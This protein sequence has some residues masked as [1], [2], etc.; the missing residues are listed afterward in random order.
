MKPAE[1]QH[2]IPTIPRQPLS[3]RTV[4]VTRPVEQSDDFSRSLIAQG[5]TVV[6]FPTIAIAS[7]QSWDE[8]DNAVGKLAEYDGLV[9]TSSNAVRAF[10]RRLEHYRSDALLNHIKKMVIYVIG[11]QTGDTV[12]REGATPTQLPD[13]ADS[14]EF[15][16]ALVALPLEG[17]H[18]LFLKGNLT[19]SEFADHLRAR[20]V[21]IDEATV[22]QTCAPSQS[23]AEPIHNM[24]RDHRID[25]VTFFSPSSF[26][27]LLSAVPLELLS[28]TT[29]AVIGSTTAA[30]AREAGLTV[31]IVPDEPTSQK[32]VDAIVLYYQG[33]K[34]S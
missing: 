16:H 26:R 27:N 12:A 29:I 20:G 10:F 34:R 23:E 21:L 1:R 18:L 6:S 2:R 17:R 33:A 4:L 9:F 5:A 24:F 30:A 31:E 8:C 32:L 22:Y 25:V 14:G 11:A 3:G 7:P 15:A 28:T 19:G 13:V